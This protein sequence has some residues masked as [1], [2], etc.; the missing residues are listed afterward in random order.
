M[1]RVLVISAI[2]F[3]LLSTP[4][5]GQDFPRP[6]GIYALGP[7]MLRPIANRLDG[8]RDLP[9]VDGY[10][11]RMGWAD[12]ETGPGQY[13]FS[14]ID[15]VIAGLEPLGQKLTFSLF[16]SAVPEDILNDPGVETF[17][18]VGS[19]AGG[20]Q[21]ELR[22][23]TWDST[24]LVRYEAFTQALAN[25][26]VPD[27]AAGGQMV[28]LKDHSVLAQITA[29]VL[30][31]G[32]IRDKE[33]RLVSS[34]GYE[35]EK[36]IR[37]VLRSIHAIVDAFPDKFTYVGF[38]SMKDQTST[39]ALDEVLLD[40]LTM[41]FDGVANP[42]L[43][44]FQ[45][46]L[47]CSTPVPSFAWALDREQTNR[48]I[49]FQMLQAWKS[50]FSDPDKTDP[51]LTDSTGP[52]VGM[53]YAFD[54]FNSR[55]F[56]VYTAD[57]DYTGFHDALQEMHDF[58]AGTVTSVERTTPSVPAA[59]VLEQNYPNPFNPATTIRYQLPTPG[60]VELSIYDLSGR[61]VRTLVDG[62]QN[63]GVHTVVWDG[64]DA[65][66]QATASGIYFYRLV[67]GGW[68]QV[69]RMLRLR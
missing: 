26:M 15:S 45:E 67:A 62:R 37:A 21:D 5:S 3:T 53:Q 58:L 59:L 13:D 48:P 46:N 2:A 36:F 20:S 63:A 23:V 42:R 51:C 1:K 7:G 4:V 55:Y 43:G 41:E 28:A 24:A 65:R 61:R 11:W 68:V 52:D 6:T 44:L 49:L 57:L 29:S 66:G 14:P 54:T 16:A 10:A 34:P 39:P 17:L 30:G 8:I 50:P 19:R 56:E 60:Q 31:L 40:S 64:R 25:Y 22:P 9:F 69:R 27:A 38:F 33:Q 47:A 32:F 35:R 12:F 18:G